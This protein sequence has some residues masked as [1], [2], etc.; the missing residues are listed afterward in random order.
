MAASSQN[1]Q[2]PTIFYPAKTYR[3]MDTAMAKLPSEVGTILKENIVL[4]L[5]GKL[6]I[7]SE[8]IMSLYIQ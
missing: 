5:G 2:T 6:T 3:D 1:P 4:Y 8:G 7:I